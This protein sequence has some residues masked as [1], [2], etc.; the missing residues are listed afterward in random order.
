M[1]LIFFILNYENMRPVKFCREKVL[2]NLDKYI[3]ELFYSMYVCGYNINIKLKFINY[4]N[5][6]PPG[7][8]DYLAVVVV[9]VKPLVIFMILRVAGAGAAAGVFERPRV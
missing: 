4:H 9:V 7:T 6:P 8:N 1:G 3:S 5:P 2:I